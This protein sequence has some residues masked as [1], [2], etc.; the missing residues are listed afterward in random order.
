[1]LKNKLLFSLKNKCKFISNLRNYVARD[2]S[3][4]QKRI[5]FSGIQPTGIPHL[6]NYLGAIKNWVSLQNNKSESELILYSIVDLHALTIPKDAK[7]L[8]KSKIE[9]TIIL[10]ACGI[11]PKKCLIFE[12]SKVSAHSELSWVLNCITPIGWLSRMTQ[13]KTKIQE[14]K[15]I[16]SI[17][18][19]NMSTGLD[20]GL[21][22]YPVL[23]AADILLYKSTHVP[24]GDDQVQHLEL[25]RNIAEKFNKLYKKSVFPLPQTILVPAKRILSLKDPSKKMS[26]SSP[27]EFSRISLTDSPEEISQKINRAITDSQKGISYSP[28]TRPG[29]SNLITIYSNFT[30]L[31]TE[32]VVNKYKDNDNKMFKDSVTEIVVTHLQPIQKEI[33]KLKK[34]EGYIKDVLKDGANKAN[35]IA[36]KNLKEVY[37]V[38]GLCN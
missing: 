3:K 28:D 13:W 12:Q 2:N 34:E 21:F 29:I 17:E 27:F 20:L 8:Q 22:A 10:L 19:I 37:A 31:T 30:G 7:M 5:T 33:E 14:Q 36:E 32:Q 4:K 38:I 9:T 16:H 1:M 26:K 35:E 11:N 18:D 23:Q 6:G 24:V 25:T 15:N